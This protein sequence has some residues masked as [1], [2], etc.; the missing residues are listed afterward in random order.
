MFKL[1]A[2]TNSRSKHARQSANASAARRLATADRSQVRGEGPGHTAARS[3][4]V[5]VVDVVVH[6]FWHD[7]LLLVAALEALGRR[8]EAEAAAVV[9]VAGG[10]LIR[11]RA[12][13]WARAR[14]T[15]YGL[16]G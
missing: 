4:V 9:I 15:G 6:A 5:V 16:R 7:A 2:T 12:R 11:A 3:L 14:V 10:V 13:F 1:S 8:H